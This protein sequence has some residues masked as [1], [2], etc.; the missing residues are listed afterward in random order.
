MF[1]KGLVPHNSKYDGYERIGKDGFIEV[2]ISHGKFVLKHR[3]EWEKVNGKIP[4]NH[5]LRCV[6]G[7]QLN[8]DPSNWKLISRAENMLINTIHRF[9]AELKSTIKALSKLKNIISEK[10]N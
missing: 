4:P 3:Y 6:D 5:I 7:N 10:Q 2:R 9:P 8:T 1:Q